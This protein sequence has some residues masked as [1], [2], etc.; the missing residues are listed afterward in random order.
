MPTKRS[1][2]RVVKFLREKALAADH[3]QYF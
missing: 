1:N 2:A 3:C